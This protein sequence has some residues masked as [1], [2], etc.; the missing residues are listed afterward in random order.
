[1]RLSAPT[2]ARCV[3][4]RDRRR[5]LVL[6]GSSH[7]EPIATAPS[8]LQA[9]LERGPSFINEVHGAFAVVLWDSDRDLLLCGRDPFGIQ[10]LFWIEVGARL[11]FSPSVESLL[12]QPGFDPAIDRFML[13]EH[14]RHRWTGREAT[15]FD[16]VHRAPPGEWLVF[17]GR[18]RRRE[19][20]WDPLPPG[21]K[22]EWTEDDVEG[23]FDRLFTT[24]VRRDLA[25]NNAGIFLSGGLD[26]VGIAVEAARQAR[27]ADRAPPH[28][29]CLVLPHPECDEE[30]LQ[31]G[32]ASKLGMD[33]SLIP[34]SEAV[35]EWGLLAASLELTRVSPAPL[36]NVWNAAFDH[37]RKEGLRSRSDRKWWRRLAGAQPLPC[38]R[39]SGA[40]ASYRVA[41]PLPQPE[42]L[43]SRPTAA[44]VAHASRLLRR[45]GPCL[46]DGRPHCES[47][48]AR[49]P[50]AIV[51]TG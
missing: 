49:A 17:E 13:A 35:G 45:E 48:L 12:A 31:R 34:L 18:T 20:F 33:L 24:A 9:Y 10:P 3:T 14:L 44:V 32:V 19:R 15:Y 43:F 41:E 39:L 42:Q 40:L 51:A 11:V 36:F 46:R 29:L 38:G 22:V 50:H 37:G 23:H 30:T 4:S 25:G 6:D 27:L 5:C 8:L 21:Q 1:M 16:G 47:A 7:R 2:G 28:A 26:S